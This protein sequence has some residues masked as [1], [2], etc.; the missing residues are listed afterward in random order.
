M[1]EPE[2]TA[3]P[4]LRWRAMT[5]PS[6]RTDPPP[7][8][9]FEQARIRR[10]NVAQ[11]YTDDVARHQITRR[12]IDPLAIP[13]HP[14]LDRELRLRAEIALPAWRSSQ[15][16]TTALETSKTRMMKKSGQCRT[17]PDRIT[18]TS[19]IHG[20]GPRN[21]EEF[22]ERIGF[23]FFNLVRPYWS[24]AFAPRLD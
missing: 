13:F 2:N 8:V 10:H 24:A 1:I 5:P 3:S 9:A 14:G 16:P 19:I 11:A 18:A 21:S 23:L 7:R 6:A 22:Q 12:R 15:K 20:M 4:D 17:T